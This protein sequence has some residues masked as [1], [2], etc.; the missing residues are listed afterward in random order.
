MEVTVA[1]VSWNTRELLLRCL[2]SLHDEALGDRVEV[3]V[4]D[5]GSSDGSAEAVK[6]R[7]PWVQLIE[8]EENLGF[9][10][11]VNL[12]ARRATGEWLLALNADVA[13]GPGAL[14]ALL[15]AGG[16]PAV[17]C[18]APRLILPGGETQ[19]SV[20]PL[21]TLR[22]VAAFN[23]GLHHVS[24]RLA[25]RLCLEGFWNPDVARQVPWAIGACLLLRRSAF[26][27]VGGFDERQWMYAEDLDLGWRLGDH[28][29]QIRYEPSARVQHASGAATEG[30]FGEQRTARFL[31]ATYAMLRRRRG[32]AAMRLTAAI[33][34]AGAASRVAW[35]AP[36][37]MVLPRWRRASRA[38][39]QWLEAHIAG[40][41]E[42]STLLRPP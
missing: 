36:A 27:A 31:A 1:V 38:N 13:L 37:G 28:G 14:S 12:V 8:P 9:G 41:R 16:P 19:H 6:R 30:A 20:H 18:V 40:A 29:W 32:G 24:H 15:G 39:R 21:P 35:M 17:G 25:E 33:N 10:R 42:S 4:V 3:F 11:A 7:A 34:I 22:L 26:N 5:N 23:L 2:D